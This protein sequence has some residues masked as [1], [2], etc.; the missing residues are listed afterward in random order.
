MT[1]S[2]SAKNNTLRTNTWKCSKCLPRGALFSCFKQLKLFA[3]FL[4]VR[5]RAFT[6][7]S[8]ISSVN[9]ECVQIPVPQQYLSP[10]KLHLRGRRETIRILYSLFCVVAR[11]YAI[12]RSQGIKQPPISIN[13]LYGLLFIRLLAKHLSIY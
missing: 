8:P 13:E 11:I 2:V 10:L 7:S 1:E 12:Q 9:I 5:F 4:V 3:Y 6:A